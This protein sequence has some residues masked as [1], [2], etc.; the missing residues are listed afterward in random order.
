[1]LLSIKVQNAAQIQDGRQ[2]VFTINTCVF[3]YHLKFLHEYLNL[4]N[5]SSFTKFVF[6]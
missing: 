6:S 4:T 2:I 5:C 3:N 1:M